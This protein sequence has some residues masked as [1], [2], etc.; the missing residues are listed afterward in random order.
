MN[1]PGLADSGLADSGRAD[2]GRADADPI[3]PG[4]DDARRAATSWDCHAHVFGSYE[5]Y[6]LAADRSYTP[7]EAV[8]ED[9]AALLERLGLGH[10]VL[11]HP[12]AYGGDH[13]LLFDVL[14]ARPLWRGVIVTRPGQLT[15]FK[16]L[17]DRGI[18]GARFSHR[19]GSS[20]NFAGSASL[21][22][23]FAL[24]PTLADAGLHAELWTDGVVLP[25]IADAIRR[26]PLPV[27]IDHMGGFDAAAGVDATGFRT[28]RS[29]VSD[30]AAWV[31]CAPIG[32]CCRRRIRHSAGRS[33]A[34][35]SRRMRG[36]S[37]G[38]ATGRTCGSRPGLTP[39][40]CSKRSGT[41]LPTRPSPIESSPRTRR[42]CT[43]ERPTAHRR[44]PDDRD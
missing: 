23:L 17:R 41:G 12:S 24:A 16:G 33:I 37:S 18:R 15:T 31:R 25:E 10:G 8:A 38:E 21:E 39:L 43:P 20:A 26:L 3:N 28:L 32:T 40:P 44:R 34:R 42:R 27:V 9:Y 36:S 7:P 6:P 30:G 35:S 13:S 14:A 29:L 19:S 11:V 5:R 22:D 2:S 4:A 1:P